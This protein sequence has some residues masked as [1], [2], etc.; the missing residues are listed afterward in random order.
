MNRF[1]WSL[2]LHGRQVIAAL[3]T[4]ALMFATYTRSQALGDEDREEE[5]IALWDWTLRIDGEDCHLYGTPMLLWRS[6][7]FLPARRTAA[8]AG[9]DYI[10]YASW[11][12]KFGGA[13]LI[14]HTLNAWR[15]EGTIQR[16]SLTGYPED[17]RRSTVVHEFDDHS[18]TIEHGG[19]HPFEWYGAN[20][21]WSRGLTDALGAHIS[22]DFEG[23]TVYI[24]TDQSPII[25]RTATW[26]DW[27]SFPQSL[28]DDTTYHMSAAAIR[29]MY[30]YY[31]LTRGWMADDNMLRKLD[32]AGAE[33]LDDW[34]HSRVRVYV[35]G[36]RTVATD[37]YANGSG[38]RYAVLWLHN[39]DQADAWIESL[40]EQA[41]AFADGTKA[42]NAGSA[43]VSLMAYLLKEAKGL[44][45]V[46][47][48]LGVISAVANIAS[49]AVARDYRI[50]IKAAQACID[51]ASG[52]SVGVILKKYQGHDVVGCVA[53]G[54]TDAP[55][56]SA[57]NH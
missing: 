12:P 21:V 13:M 32:V 26:A 50:D 45:T 3:L 2:R 17:P 54:Y 14:G 16:L 8:C 5:K 38:E 53:S 24:R 42:V 28:S 18:V 43:V 6:A 20:Y 51:S 44:S 11:L 52:Q 57:G 49:Y 22:A 40:E 34:Q 7:I 46:S 56:N 37:I 47:P 41:A 29:N 1:R 25:T 19:L 10:S 48:Y 31:V 39:Q 23:K 36:T 4:I 55:V 27:N 30:D 15:P 9:W 33:Y 35:P